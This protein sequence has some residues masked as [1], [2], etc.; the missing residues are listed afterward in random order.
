MLNRQTWTKTN[1]QCYSQTKD[2]KCD[3]KNFDKALF[4]CLRLIIR[5][6]WLVQGRM[7]RLIKDSR[8][9]SSISCIVLVFIWLRSNLWARRGFD[10]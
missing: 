9:Q 2:S 3:P 7:T 5:L 8:G 4:D 1:T 6:F 10:F